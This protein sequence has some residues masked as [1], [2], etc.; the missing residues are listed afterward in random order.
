[1]MKHCI[2]ISG[3]TIALDTKLVTELQKIAAVVTNLDN[4]NVE[5][6]IEN[7]QVDL[8]LLEIF[9]KKRSEIEMIKTIKNR[10]PRVE[11]ILINGEGNQDLIAKAFKYG[12]RDAFRKPYKIALIVERVNAILRSKLK[13]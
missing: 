9:N 10:Y 3:S 11:I 5:S 12:A 7:T 2:L 13:S 1:M 4:S 6:F 8:I